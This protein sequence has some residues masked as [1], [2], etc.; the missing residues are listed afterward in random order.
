MLYS[1]SLRITM[2]F[3]GE[4]VTNHHAILLNFTYWAMHDFSQLPLS[5]E[6]VRYI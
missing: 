3:G 5:E 2:D 4:V 6:R 1:M